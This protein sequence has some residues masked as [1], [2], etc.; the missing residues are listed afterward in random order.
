[1][2]TTRN[3]V[4][5]K[6]KRHILADMKVR[7]S[8]EQKIK[9]ANSDDVFRIMQAV[10]LRHSRIHR[11]REMFWTMGLD[12][13]HQI[14]Y[15][16]LV[17]LGK[18][19]TVNVDPIEIFSFASQKKCKQVILIHNHPSGS[20]KPSEEDILVTTRLAIGAEFLGMKVLDHLIINE[21]DYTSIGDFADLNKVR[22][23]IDKIKG[24]TTTAKLKKKKK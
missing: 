24:K 10:L 21:K 1:M 2:S 7:L 4:H 14:I 18:I 15:L 23:A 11:M 20:L 13:A 9:I 22:G 5:R 12:S 3:K 19:N 6:R 17:A 8:K 16:E